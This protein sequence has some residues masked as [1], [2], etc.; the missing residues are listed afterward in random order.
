MS[1]RPSLPAGSPPT[2]EFI[3]PLAEILRYFTG[4]AR[5]MAGKRDG[6]AFL[7]LSADGFWRSFAAIVVALPP[8]AL[9]WIEFERV[10]RR[11]PAPN[12]SDT[13]LY[14][15]HAFA[16]LTAWLFPMLVLML[17]A[18]PAGLSRKLVPLVVS[19]NWGSA[20]LAWGFTPLWLLLI[21]TGPT[22][23]GAILSALALLGAVWLTV[24]LVATALSIDLLASAGIVLLTMV[25]SLMAYA[26]V[27]DVTGISFL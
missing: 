1:T 12:L 18:R 25:A 14:G 13:A 26:A 21:L 20:L 3:P 27:T 22:D 10:E 8:T 16:D 17:L 2:P 15:A 6:L 19:L 4:A 24:R 5:L 7:D 9:S 23:M 11:G